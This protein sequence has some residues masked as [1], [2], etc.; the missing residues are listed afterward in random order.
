M[1]NIHSELMIRVAN[2]TSIV[3]QLETVDGDWITTNTPD[4]LP[5]V[6]YRE[7]P[8]ELPFELPKLDSYY[9]SIDLDVCS[10]VTYENDNYDKERLANNNVFLNE[11]QAELVQEHLTNSFWFIRK[12][13]EFASKSEGTYSVFY[14]IDIHEWYVTNLLFSYN[15]T[16]ILMSKEAAE[17]F[18][19]WLD[20]FAPKGELLIKGDN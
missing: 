19:Q 15:P 20:K 12:A 14:N 9:W 2:D 1:K 18:E 16:I 13:T 7:K 3:V 4:W 8:A 10:K 5:S 6:N 11:K 17:K